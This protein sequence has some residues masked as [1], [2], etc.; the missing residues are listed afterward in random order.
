MKVKLKV[1]DVWQQRQ[2]YYYSDWHSHFQYFYNRTDA[3]DN[4]YATIKAAN[5]VPTTASIAT[6]TKKQKNNNTYDVIPPE[7][8]AML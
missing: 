4:V 5:T 3:A 1:V 6:N 7:V 2:Y 8:I